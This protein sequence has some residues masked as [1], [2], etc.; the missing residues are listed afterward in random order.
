MKKVLCLVD[1]IARTGFGTV[2]KNI[3]SELRKQY[4]ESLKLHIIAINY[5]GEPFYE[6]DNTYVISAR[7]NDINDDPFGRFFF[8]KTLQEGDW[9]GVFICQDLGTIVPSIEVM[10]HIKAEKKAANKKQFK[11]IFYFPMDCDPQKEL[12]RD[13]EFFDILVTYTEYGRKLVRKHR[14]ELKVEVVPHG[15]NFKEFYPINYLDNDL[16]L[17]RETYFRE[18]SDRFIVLS[19]NRNQP[20]KDFPTTILGF[21][22]AVKNWPSDMPRP[23]LYLH[24][25]P[26]DPMGWDLKAILKQTSLIED[27]DYKLLPD[28]YLE[29]GCD[30]ETLNKIYNVSDCLLVTPTGEGWGLSVSEAAATKLPIICPNHTSLGEMMNEERA[31]LLES[32]Y[33]TISTVDNVIRFQSD[34]GEVADAILH[35]AQHKEERFEKAEKAY[36]WVE[37][38]DWNILCK[39]WIG[40]FRIF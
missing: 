32:Q 5:F 31:Y 24:T 29:Q 3:I 21:E 35:V 12:L 7:R 36:Q 40:Y 26:K 27:E 28:E 15:N 16:N 19:V 23:L 34:I 30:I 22:E 6:D 8:L 33:P 4:G 2:S 14:P 20:R 17:F 1:Y 9:D 38:L 18:L 11:S 25:H 37:N 39:R 10:R 13:L